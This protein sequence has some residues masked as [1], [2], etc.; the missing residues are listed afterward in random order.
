MDK[1]PLADRV[2]CGG[3]RLPRY[4]WYMLSGAIC[5]VFQFLID[6]VVY[7]SALVAMLPYERDTVSWTVSYVLTIALRHETHRIFVFG[8]YEGSYWRN[9]GKMYMTYATTIAASIVLRSMLAHAA[10]YLPPI[11]LAY[12]SARTY[13]YFATMLFTGIFSYFALKRSWGTNGGGAGGA[14]AA[15]STSDGKSTRP[16]RSKKVEV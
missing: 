15:G 6:R 13:G 10:E 8:A 14:G 4:A 12:A 11:L 16:Q 3:R 1:K 7:T 9:L 5:D 2:R